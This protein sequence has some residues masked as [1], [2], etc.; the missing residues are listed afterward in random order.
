MISDFVTNLSKRIDSF[1][2]GCIFF[3]CIIGLF[4]IYSA[5]G[6][7]WSRVL[8]QFINMMVA[9][10]L[11]WAVANITPHWLERMALPLF[12][13]GLLLL[14]GVALFG[15][16]SHGARRWLNL[17][18][19]RIQPSELM[20]VGMPMMLAWYFARREANLRSVD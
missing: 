2:M 1:L 16:I 7:D 8:S 6:Q 20:K 19:A 13:L 3:A 5:S 14:L 10:T 9:L 18:F 12:V 15:E 11:M 17:G 4:V